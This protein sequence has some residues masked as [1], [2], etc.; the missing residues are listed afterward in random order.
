MLI[1]MASTPITA[2]HDQAAMLMQVCDQTATIQKQT[3]ALKVAN[4]Q[5]LD[6][7]VRNSF[8]AL[9]LIHHA[10]SGAICFFIR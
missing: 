3:D 6:M 1:P 7:A 5:L 8:I 9:V 10:A 2:V 4:A